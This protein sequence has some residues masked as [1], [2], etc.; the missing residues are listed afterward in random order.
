MWPNVEGQSF[1]DCVDVNMIR[2]HYRTKDPVYYRHVTNNLPPD[3]RTDEIFIDRFYKDKRRRRPQ[4][5]CSNVPYVT[6][7]DRARMDKFLGEKRRM[8]V[9][10]MTTGIVAHRK[11]PSQSHLKP[12]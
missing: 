5:N 1:L 9:T 12:V 2:N 4:K 8:H 10:V 11:T 6:T 7:I 3:D